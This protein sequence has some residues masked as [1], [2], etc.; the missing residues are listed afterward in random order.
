MCAYQTGDCAGPTVGLDTVEKKKF[1]NSTENRNATH[2]WG[3]TAEKYYNSILFF[4]ISIFLYINTSK[5]DL[6]IL[7][8]LK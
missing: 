6:K 4:R 5:K 8:F 3:G 7:N 1:P 2:T